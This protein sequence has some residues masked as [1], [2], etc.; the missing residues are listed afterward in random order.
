MGWITL[1]PGFTTEV[2]SWDSL[3]GSA[4]NLA[5][6][7]NSRVDAGSRVVQ[8]DRGHTVHSML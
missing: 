1:I 6:P 7:E 8:R 2:A 4:Y 3:G 5:T